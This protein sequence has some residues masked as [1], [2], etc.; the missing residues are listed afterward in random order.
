MGRAHVRLFGSSVGL[1]FEVGM[2]EIA[3][4]ASGRR[5]G[6]DTGRPVEAHDVR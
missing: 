3:M 4:E 5:A 2:E 1:E 6:G